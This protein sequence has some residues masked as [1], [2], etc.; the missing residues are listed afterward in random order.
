[1]QSTEQTLLVEH[2]CDDEM[3]NENQNC[4]EQSGF[5][6]SD[7]VGTSGLNLR[8]KIRPS[9]P[10]PAPPSTGSRN[11]TPVSSNANTPTRIR[12]LSSNRDILPP[13]PPI[14]EGVMNIS[15]PKT[16]SV[17]NGNAS[18]GISLQLPKN[19]SSILLNL[20]NNFTTSK[21]ANISRPPNYQDLVSSPQSEHQVSM[22]NSGMDI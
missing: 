17:G 4:C 15:P 13:P 18:L 2:F 21:L 3:F 11:G 8:M 1:M 16:L 6:T 10:P 9:Q 12:N 5:F 7:G 22:H 20:D 19:K 14:P